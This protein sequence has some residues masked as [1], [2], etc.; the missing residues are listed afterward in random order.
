VLEEGFAKFFSAAVEVGADGVDGE[1]E[2]L[3]D[4]LVGALFLVVEDEDGTLGEGEALEVFVDELGELVFF[5]LLDG[6]GGGMLEAALPVCVVGERD[7]AAVFAA[8][9]LPLVL[10]DVDGDAVEVSGD[11]GIAAK[12]GEGAVETEEDVLGEVFEVLGA[13]EASEGA[14]DHRLMVLDDLLEVGLSR[15]RVGLRALDLRALD[16]TALDHRVRLKF[17]GG[18]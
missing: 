14:E 4:L 15:H 8:A 9:T 5:E 13:D 16:L 12:V 18:N 2:G 10:G 3:G 6:V 7:V 11:L 17:H 1:R